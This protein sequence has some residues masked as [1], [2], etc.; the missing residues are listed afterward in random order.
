MNR[1]LI[2]LAALLFTIP[3]RA[4]D[5]ITFT[6][7]AYK[8]MTTIDSKSSSFKNDALDRFK[9]LFDFDGFYARV[10]PDI[11]AKMSEEDTAKLKEA[12]EDLFFTNFAAKTAS[13]ASRKIAFPKY[14]IKTSATE[15]T[16]V[17][18]S[19]NL[20]G[21][22]N[23]TFAFALKPVAGATWRLVDIEVDSVLLS[24]NYRG[25]FNRTFRE[26]GASGLIEKLNAK[27]REI[28]DTP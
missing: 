25:A 6:A 28:T 21:G 4:E 1:I 27:R 8:T 12:F 26:N 24:R 3:A 11:A 13:I 2:L 7:T 9:S 18:A 5:A 20:P 19:G 17:S 10:T 15:I 22:G 14:A 23:A 16:V